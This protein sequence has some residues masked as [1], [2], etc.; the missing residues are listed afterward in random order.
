M[1]EQWLTRKTLLCKITDPQDNAAWNEFIE[2]YGRFIYHIILKMGVG[3]ANADD[4]AQQI[5]LTLWQKINT[6]DS[7][8]GHFRPWLS[9]VIRNSVNQHFRREIRRLEKA[10]VS[11]EEEELSSTSEVD[12][13]IQRE[14]EAYLTDEALQRV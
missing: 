9:T 12:L 4:I 5:A 6:Y 11:A 14:W 1:S 8:K 7:T 10:S 3:S 2:Y 13:M